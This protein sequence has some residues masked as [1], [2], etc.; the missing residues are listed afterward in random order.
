MLE[1]FEILHHFKAYEFLFTH[2]T[3]PLTEQLLIDTHK[4][5]TQNTIQYTKGYE[6]GAYTTTQMAAGDTVFP[7]HEISIA[8]VPALMEQTQK[9]IDESVAHPVEIAAKFH[10]YFIYLHPFPDGNGRLGRLLS[11][12]ILAKFRHPIIIIIT[13]GQKDAYFKALKAAHKHKDPD[14]ISA[15]FIRTSIARMNDELL[16][17]RTNAA[18]E[19]SNDSGK[20]IRGLS[21]AF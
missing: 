19:T 20:Q 5:L 11:N 1:A 17:I 12:F 13:A 6:P 16:Q 4:I 2:L 18:Q 7:N 14:I 8:N 3:L 21:F 9:A 10:K 15:F